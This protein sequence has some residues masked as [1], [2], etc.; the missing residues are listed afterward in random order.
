MLGA[1]HAEC[2]TVRQI[3][4]ALV[5]PPSCQDW[6]YRQRGCCNG[7][8]K[9]DVSVGSKADMAT[10]PRA[11]Y[12]SLKSRHRLLVYESTPYSP[13][14]RPNGLNPCFASQPRMA[15]A[16][17]ALLILLTLPRFVAPDLLLPRRE[18]R[19]HVAVVAAFGVGDG[20]QKSFGAV[21]KAQAQ[22]VG[23]QE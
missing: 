22:H 18:P 2:A 8:R 12:F 10:T 15:A 20:E 16:P 6:Q 11:V 19:F 3:A 13:L 7:W 23:A 9:T 21:K 17:A 4:S 14:C 5:R 1:A